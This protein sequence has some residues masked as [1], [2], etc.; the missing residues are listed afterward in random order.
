MAIG[1]HRG[2]TTENSDDGVVMVEFAPLCPG[3]DPMKC[4]S[5][6][7]E[8]PVA[9]FG[10]PLRCPDCGIFYEKAVELKLEREAK[11]TRHEAPEPGPNEARAV[12]AAVKQ[13]SKCRAF[14]DRK[15][16][17]C[18]SCRTKQTRMIG[19]VRGLIIIA[20]ATWFFVS[21]FGS[22]DSTAPATASSPSTAASPAPEKPKCEDPVMAFVMSQN[23]VKQRLKSP[24]TADFP[25]S[26]ADG[27][28]IAKIAE[29]SY[30]VIAFV[31][32]QNGFGATIRSRYSVNMTATPDG[33]RWSAKE[34]VIQ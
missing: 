11:Q 13:C 27:V 32:S 23:F 26:G 30:Q 3:R 5:C 15:A 21:I 14:M 4:P 33:K 22:S 7:H 17:V 16:T 2:G 24:S 12:S 10:E 1:R 29:C 34:L 20:A 9:D 31:D 28:H 8:A 6:E 18:P 19:T 25:Y